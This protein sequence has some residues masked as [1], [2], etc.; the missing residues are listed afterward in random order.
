MV[1]TKTKNF[2]VFVLLEADRVSHWVSAYT[3][4][5]TLT[6]ISSACSLLHHYFTSWHPVTEGSADHRLKTVP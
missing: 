4:R 2:D 6:P 5:Q 1:E 3:L